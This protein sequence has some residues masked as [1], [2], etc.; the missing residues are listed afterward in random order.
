MYLE[1]TV[2]FFFRKR[3]PQ[4]HGPQRNRQLTGH[5]EMD[6]KVLSCLAAVR[7]EPVTRI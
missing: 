3:Q 5:R 6:L 1:V 2:D 7:F 4:I